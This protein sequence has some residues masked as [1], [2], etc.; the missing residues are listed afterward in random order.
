[1]TRPLLSDV[2]EALLVSIVDTGERSDPVS[3][4]A[5]VVDDALIELPLEGTL[6]RGPDG[7]PLLLASPPFGT[8]KTG[9][10]RPMHLARIHLVAHREEDG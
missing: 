3:G 7:G 10:D 6:T 1:M 4:T 8:M 2:I 9:F 5:I